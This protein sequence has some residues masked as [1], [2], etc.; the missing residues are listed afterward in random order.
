MAVQVTVVWLMQLKRGS[1]CDFLENFEGNRQY[2]FILTPAICT[3]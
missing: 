3:G 2:P 1:S